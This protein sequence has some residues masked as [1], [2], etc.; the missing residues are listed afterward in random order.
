[1]RL[2]VHVENAPFIERT[3]TVIKSYVYNAE[4]KTVKDGKNNP[5]VKT[6]Y[7][8]KKSLCIMNTLSFKGLTDQ[9]DVNDALAS[10]RSN[11]KI[12]KW[13]DGREQIYVCNEK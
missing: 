12:A 5:I 1:M 4:G 7:K 2:T 8:P 6:T 3:R 11:Y 9:K 10:V 13:K